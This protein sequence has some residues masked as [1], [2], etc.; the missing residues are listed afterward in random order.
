MKEKKKGDGIIR[1]TIAIPPDINKKIEDAR[2][3]V[4]FSP[5][6][7][8]VIAQHLRVGKYAKKKSRS[9]RNKK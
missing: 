5:W 6:V 2:G 1:R 9:K 4:K 7:V 8:D 3:M